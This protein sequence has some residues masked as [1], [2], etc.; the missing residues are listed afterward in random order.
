M[1]KVT[2]KIDRKVYKDLQ[3]VKID[4]DA[5][6][7]SSA[8]EYLLNSERLALELQAKKWKLNNTTSTKYSAN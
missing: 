6:S 3:K 5:K 2:M 8:I 1:D 4:I 7:L